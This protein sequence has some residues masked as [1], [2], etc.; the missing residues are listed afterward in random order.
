MKKKHFVIRVVGYGRMQHRLCPWLSPRTNSL[1]RLDFH[2]NVEIAADAALYKDCVICGK[3]EKEATV[4]H[5]SK[6]RNKI[7]PYELF[8]KMCLRNSCLQP[9][10]S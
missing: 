4:K 6:I 5:Q 3:I 9:C 10:H 8:Q 7:S 2:C 1:T